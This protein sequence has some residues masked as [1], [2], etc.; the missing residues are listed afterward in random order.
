MYKFED[1][2]IEVVYNCPLCSSEKSKIMHNNIRDWSFNAIDGSWQI[3]QC[4]ICESMYLSSR[5]AQTYIG[6][7]YSQYYTHSASNNSSF[8]SKLENELLY[9]WINVNIEPRLNSSFKFL[10]KVIWPLL[11]Y[12]YPL[13]EIVKLPRGTV[14]D[15][16]CGSGNMLKILGSIGWEVYGIEIDEK[17]AVAA[18]KQGINVK[19]GT[20]ELAK[21]FNQEFDCVVASHVIEHIYDPKYF[22]ETL[23]NSTKINGKIY[24][25]YPNPHSLVHRLFGKY[26][27]GLEAPRHISLP[28]TNWIIDYVGRLGHQCK[29]TPSPIITFWGS[30]LMRFEKLPFFGRI[31]GKVLQLIP[32]YFF[33]IRN[34]DLVQLEIIK[35]H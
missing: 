35:R 28:S 26:W 12:R 27:R 22:I 34:S 2:E 24:I 17:A 5:P 18:S 3:V 10:F 29:I 11:L 21:D 20:F 31:I 14:L 9:H 30:Y 25:S 4:E 23:I 32:I 1:Q 13:E 15:I 8:I 33:S 19:K 7:A 6:H 16:G